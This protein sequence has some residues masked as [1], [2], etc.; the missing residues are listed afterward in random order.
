MLNV[1]AKLALKQIKRRAG[2]IFGLALL[3]PVVCLLDS[4]MLELVPGGQTHAA[5]DVEHIIAANR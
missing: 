3:I 2:L 1:I 5:L 4:M